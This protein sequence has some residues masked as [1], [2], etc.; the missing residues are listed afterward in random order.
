MIDDIQNDNSELD[1]IFETIIE[2]QKDSLAFVVEMLPVI[3]HV[4]KAL[5]KEIITKGIF[6]CINELDYKSDIEFKDD[7]DNKGVFN[8]FSAL[9]KL[10]DYSDLKIVMFEILSNDIFQK[11]QNDEKKEINYFGFFG[12]LNYHSEE[13]IPFPH[14]S[15]FKKYATKN[16]NLIRGYFNFI[17]K[18]SNDYYQ[19]YIIDCET[20]FGRENV[21]LKLKSFYTFEGNWNR[22]IEEFIDYYSKDE[23]F[24]NIL[25]N[26]RLSPEEYESLYVDIS[27]N[28]SYSKVDDFINTM[29]N[30]SNYKDSHVKCLVGLKALGSLLFLRYSFVIDK[31]SNTRDKFI[32]KVSSEI[33]DDKLMELIRYF[34]DNPKESPTEK[35]KKYC[36]LL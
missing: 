32:E 4:G 17:K 20:Y 35:M 22:P 5:K 12:E 11:L 6:H 34:N 2:K 30:L 7:L 33:T 19:E 13:N 24:E 28:F 36:G 27:E 25:L 1:N 29:N 9:Q 16:P 18:T 14:H 31:V 26:Q 8:V 23:N 15:L 21:F 10:L 3:N